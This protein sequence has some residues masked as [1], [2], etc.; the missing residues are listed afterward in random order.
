[1]T[2]RYFLAISAALLLLGCRAEPKQES[3]PPLVGWRPIGSWSGSGTTQTESFDIASG[4][5]R[6]KWET[7][8]EAPPGAGR[9]KLTANSAVS[10]RFIA[11]VV[12]HRG[13]GRG[14]AYVTD[15]PRMFYL[16]IESSGVEWTVSVEEGV[17][18][19]AQGPR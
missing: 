15:D 8:N 14:T 10:G 9:F 11:P 2:T 18:G 12:E 4:Q 17:T 1:M 7:K 13:A 6:V 3:Q 19:G 5:F 16:L